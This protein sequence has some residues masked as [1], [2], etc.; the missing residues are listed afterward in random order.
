MVVVDKRHISHNRRCV[1]S[2]C[3]C[4]CASGIRLPDRYPGRSGVVFLAA[5]TFTNQDSRTMCLMLQRCI[6]DAPL[7]MLLQVLLL[8]FGNCGRHSCLNSLIMK[9]IQAPFELQPISNCIKYKLKAI[10]LIEL[11]RKEFV[12]SIRRPLNRLVWLRV[13]YFRAYSL[14]ASSSSKSGVSDVKLANYLTSNSITTHR[15]LIKSR[16]SLAARTATPS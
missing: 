15:E 10:L 5:D 9:N 8:T 12:N 2:V 14:D 4:L 16:P 11:H 13:D 1:S 6:S 7:Q 3:V